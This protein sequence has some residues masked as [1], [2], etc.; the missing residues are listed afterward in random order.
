MVEIRDGLS[1]NDSRNEW[2]E[3]KKVPIRLTRPHFPRR[4]RI[5]E[6]GPRDGLQNESAIVPAADKV[7][8]INRLSQTGL[9]TVE[10]TRC[11]LILIIFIL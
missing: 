7:E 1:N 5:V 3:W 4:V 9:Q 11:V 2:D 6:V 10:V 8:F